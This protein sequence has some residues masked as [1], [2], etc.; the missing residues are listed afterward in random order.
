MKKNITITKVYEVEREVIR[1]FFVDTSDGGKHWYKYH[2]I[3]DIWEKA[4]DLD[5]IPIKFTIVESEFEK[6]SLKRLS[7]KDLAPDVQKVLNRYAGGVR[8]IQEHNHLKLVADLTEEISRCG[9]IAVQNNIIKRM[10]GML[11]TERDRRDND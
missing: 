4:V 7:I 5:A 8:G 6:E 10:K 9:V 11:E 1:S 2:E 3:S